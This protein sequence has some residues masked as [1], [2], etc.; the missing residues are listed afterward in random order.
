MFEIAKIAI[1][2][3]KLLW[4]SI[5][6]KL[7][8]PSEKTDVHSMNLSG[9]HVEGKYCSASAPPLN[10]TQLLVQELRTVKLL[11]LKHVVFFASSKS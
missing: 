10:V 4:K 11:T 3:K 6:G 9:A 1:E 5:E 8:L 7:V 2:K